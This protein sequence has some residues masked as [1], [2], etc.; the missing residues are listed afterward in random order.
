[1]TGLANDRSFGEW[2]AARAVFLAPPLRNCLFMSF[3]TT[4]FGIRCLCDVKTR[5]KRY[6]LGGCTIFTMHKNTII[7]SYISRCKLTWNVEYAKILISCRLHLDVMKIQ[8]TMWIKIIQWQR[9]IDFDRNP[10]A[11][12]I[13]GLTENVRDWSFPIPCNAYFH[14]NIICVEKDIKSRLY[15][16][17]Q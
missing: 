7:V 8:E 6:C 13:K 4:N 14:R 1:M 3:F 2:R 16:G 12:W 15:Q 10:P 17:K 11:S 5:N 9:S